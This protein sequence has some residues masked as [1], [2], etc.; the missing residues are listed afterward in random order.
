MLRCR[1]R[2]RERR[3][4][5]QLLHRKEMAALNVSSGPA[6]S[7]APTRAV[8]PPR[9]QHRHARIGLNR[10]RGSIRQAAARHPTTTQTITQNRGG[11]RPSIACIDESEGDLGA[12]TIGPAMIASQ[13]QGECGVGVAVG[14]PRVE[15]I[16]V[17]AASQCSRR[18]SQAQHDQV[19][20]PLVGRQRVPLSPPS[21][22]LNQVP[23]IEYRG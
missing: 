5:T 21:D 16:D 20:H 3:K 11:K 23:T 17:P 12:L 6:R 18:S 8:V 9:S 15:G 1:R 7:R 4:S 14:K 22:W 13:D 2:G 19:A 10:Q